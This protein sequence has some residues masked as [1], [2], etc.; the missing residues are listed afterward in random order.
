MQMFHNTT[1]VQFVGMGLQA[2]SDLSSAAASYMRTKSYLEVC[3]AD[4]FHPA[5]L[6]AAVLS[7]KDM[8]AKIGHPG[9]R[10]RF[11]SSATSDSVDQA[12]SSIPGDSFRDE[13]EQKTINSID[14]PRTRRLVALKGY[15][16]PLDFDVPAAVPP[17]NFFVKM[18]TWQAHRIASKNDQKEAKKQAKSQSRQSSCSESRERDERKLDRKLAKLDS[19]LDKPDGKRKERDVRRAQEKYDQEQ[20]KV[21]RKIEKRVEKAEK[22]EKGKGKVDDKEERQ[23]NKIR[24][25]VIDQWQGHEE[26]AV[27]DV[28]SL[29]SEQS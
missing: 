26:G 14:D 27:S 16:A 10:L 9:D 6:H 24:W 3:N 29:R 12:T 15:I 11:L 25:I 17:E 5:G 4:F 13:A 20:R 28:S 2:T 18:G 21:E 7:T 1:V 8:M 23:A 22:A 19:S